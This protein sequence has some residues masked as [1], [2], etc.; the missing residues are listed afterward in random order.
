MERSSGNLYFDTLTWLLLNLY[1][2]INIL[3]GN[4]TEELFRLSIRVVLRALNQKI[5][6]ISGNFA[7]L[8]LAKLLWRCFIHNVLI[9]LTFSDHLMFFMC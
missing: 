5:Q 2:G 6:F 8:I 4:V 7:T 9:L 1:L 3:V